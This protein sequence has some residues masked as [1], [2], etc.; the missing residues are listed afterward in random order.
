MYSLRLRQ[1]NK[2]SYMNNFF[3]FTHKENAFL[4]QKVR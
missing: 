4:G 3:K 1:Y 2:Y